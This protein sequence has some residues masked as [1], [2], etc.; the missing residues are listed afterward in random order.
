MAKTF[1][2]GS[3]LSLGSKKVREL[4]ISSS[5]NLIGSFSVNNLRDEVARAI[6]QIPGAKTCGFEFELYIGAADGDLMFDLIFDD[7][8]TEFFSSMIFLMYGGCI[9]RLLK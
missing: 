2:S 6:P 3:V 4:A 7:D 1:F 8:S 9:I 5:G